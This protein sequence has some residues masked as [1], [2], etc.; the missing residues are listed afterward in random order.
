MYQHVAL[1]G[2]L[3]VLVTGC[4]TTLSSLQTAK[5]LQPGHVRLSVGQGIYV[6]ATQAAKAITQGIDL[7]RQTAEQLDRNEAPMLTAEQEQAW[8]TS[9]LALAV[10]PPSSQFEAMLR[11]GLV[12]NLD[13]GLKYSSNALRLDGRYRLY[14]ASRY[15][16]LSA[17]AQQSTGSPNQFVQSLTKDAQQDSTDI[18]LGV[19]VS[20]Y[21]F[22]SP[23]VE[24]LQFVKMGDFSRWDVDVTLYLS[25]DFI[26]Y[27]GLYGAVKYVWSRTDS[28]QTLVRFS[29][30]ASQIIKTDVSVPARVD[31]HFLGGTFGLRAGIPQISLYLE[32]TVGN[33]WATAKVLQ[34][35]RSIGGLTLYPAVGLA[36]AW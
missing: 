11:L 7:S 4:S 24:F 28:D 36:S 21:L 31:A 14:H 34:E 30:Q 6:P 26:R 32:L 16:E 10:F 33:T 18:A 5:T 23:V 19:G 27:L 2:S 1:A 12:D 3:A 29:Q 9:A 8:I 22:K 17:Q 20:R 35:V 25:R 13:I 15:D